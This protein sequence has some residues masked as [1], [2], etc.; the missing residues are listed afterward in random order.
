[1]TT[2]GKG[3]NG[4]VDMLATVMRRAFTEAV[5]GTVEPIGDQVKALRTEVGDK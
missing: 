2:E 5:Q 4:S 1:M 3:L